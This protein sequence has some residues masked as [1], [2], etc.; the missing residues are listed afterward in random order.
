MRKESAGLAFFSFAFCFSVVAVFATADT[1]QAQEL[2]YNNNLPTFNLDTFGI[3][4]IDGL[5]EAGARSKSQIGEALV[6][7]EV[8]PASDE[9]ISVSEEVKENSSFSGGRAASDRRDLVGTT[10]GAASRN[11]SLPPVSQGLLTDLK[12]S[13]T[14]DS[15]AAFSED[16]LKCEIFEKSPYIAFENTLNEIRTSLELKDCHAQE[17]PENDLGKKF[18]EIEKAYAEIKL[19]KESTAGLDIPNKDELAK[20]QEHVN[21]VI[22]G[23]LDLA[24]AFGEG[25]SV[26]ARCG[27]P[28]DSSLSMAQNVVKLVDGLLPIANM[29]ASFG[30]ATPYIKAIVVGGKATTQ[31]ISTVLN[32]MQ[33][34]EVDMSKP[35]TRKALVTGVCQL[36]KVDTKMK[37]LVDVRTREI[38]MNSVAAKF[39][40][41]MKFIRRTLN[42]NDPS[43]IK[44]KQYYDTIQR[45]KDYRQ[46]FVKSFE[47][48]GAAKGDEVELCRRGK[49]FVSRDEGG[50]ETL[51][52]QFVKDLEILGDK[53]ETDLGD[54]TLRR[55]VVPKLKEVTAP[56]GMVI[57]PIPGFEN[58]ASFTQCLSQTR[59]LESTI[60]ST[61]NYL[62]GM[63][64]SYSKDL[65]ELAKSF[66]PLA[67]VLRRS[68]VVSQ[69]SQASLEFGKA[70]DVLLNDDS[71]FDE[72]YDDGVFAR[73]ESGVEK[74]NDLRYQIFHGNG[75]NAVKR[76][77]NKIWGFTHP[78]QR[79]EKNRSA[80]N[81]PL[82]AWFG[83]HM[84]R[85]EEER[86]I[87]KSQLKEL[88]DRVMR[89]TIFSG[90]K[91]ASNFHINGTQED[92]DDFMLALGTNVLPLAA[93]DK[94]AQKL[95]DFKVT[96]AASGETCSVLTGLLRYYMSAFDHFSAVRSMCKMIRPMFERL[97]EE[98]F[99]VINH[100]YGEKRLSD[101][102]VEKEPLYSRRM[103]DLIDGD[104]I[105]ANAIAEKM[106][107]LRCFDTIG[108]NSIKR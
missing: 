15:L 78:L 37:Y 23:G 33:S 16:E 99:T 65:Q 53:F 2:N 7:S 106:S 62:T 93:S 59:E 90:G 24:E 52:S 45:F 43:A 11:A 29:A 40:P 5:E 19:F 14:A 27:Q 68:D 107:E 64:E 77:T 60:K 58:D 42:A 32:Y 86:D 21:T 97:N 6:I 83:Y 41:A 81:S 10:T 92:K 108:Y 51:L 3:D 71:G 84:K 17:A 35:E 103:K 94:F 85:A 38:F 18:G 75:V 44:A 50:A 74:L 102:V 48:L 12:N 34:G 69:G 9:N 96:A 13:N 49:R 20:L 47:I 89:E 82:F 91:P 57:F 88:Y 66:P 1:S 73:S 31:A 26:R 54:G 79:L 36:V 80:P 101:G 22:S 39:E 28:T 63:L 87:F 98:D 72:S 70:L 30:V 61:F 56:I 67:E 4:V 76:V 8:I 95:K 104:G 25:G 105:Y 55:L 46:K 100:C